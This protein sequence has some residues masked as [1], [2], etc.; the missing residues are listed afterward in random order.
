MKA[1][2]VWCALAVAVA[3][4]LAILQPAY[5][6]PRGGIAA[7]CFTEKMLIVQDDAAAP[8]PKMHWTIWRSAL[9]RRIESDAV[10]V[11]APQNGPYDY[12]LLASPG[13]AFQ[14]S[15]FDFVLDDIGLP[16]SDS[17]SPYQS[18]IMKLPS[19]ASD[20][21]RRISSCFDDYIAS[22]SYNVLYVG[23][24]RAK[25][26]PCCLIGLPPAS[27]FDQRTVRSGSRS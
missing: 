20:A 13:R 21:S 3:S 18:D 24:C 4:I 22:T 6:A 14:L 12:S 27:A 25:R 15:R 19:A 16:V 7:I 8:L 1:Y 9:G 26:A 5:A 10:L 11:L 17:L 2:C 23:L